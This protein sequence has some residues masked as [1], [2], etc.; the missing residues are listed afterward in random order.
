MAPSPT[1]S[2]LSSTSPRGAIG[3]RSSFFKNGIPGST[4][5]ARRSSILAGT[6]NPLV[7]QTPKTG[8]I[9]GLD[10]GRLAASRDSHDP[11]HPSSTTNKSNSGR[12]LV[13]PSSN[14]TAERARN[15]LVDR[16]KRGVMQE[17]EMGDGDDDQQQIRELTGDEYKNFMTTYD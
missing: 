4:T 13:S 11:G 6:G 9:P 2:E 3:H 17:S 15:A 10:M 14:A 1:N 16:L 5:N 8:G 12:P 7:A